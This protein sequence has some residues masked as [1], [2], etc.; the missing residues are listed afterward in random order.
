MLF[1]TLQK[2]RQIDAWELGELELETKTDRKMSMSKMSMMSSQL[3]LNATGLESFTL[4]TAE[5]ERS[6]L[7]SLER[8]WVNHEVR[9]SC[10]ISFLPELIDS[11]LLSFGW[12]C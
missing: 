6:R 7:I 11:N 4:G 9:A 3:H 1:N 5:T 12:T 2:R 10:R 8:R